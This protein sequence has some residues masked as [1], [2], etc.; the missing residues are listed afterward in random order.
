MR[1]F[2]PR[3]CTSVGLIAFAGAL[4]LMAGADEHTSYFP[5]LFVAFTLLG[6]GAGMSFMPLLT[7]ALAAVPS[8][9]AGLAS[10]M[11]NVSMQLSAAVGLAVLGSISSARTSAL[12]AQ[13]VA[14]NAAL[15]DGFHVAFVVAAACVGVGLI[16]AQVCLPSPAAVRSADEHVAAVLDA[17]SWEVDPAA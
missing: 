2:G 17:E 16:A 14:Q 8:E 4:V 1:R 6:V 10:G 7:I 12:L 15:I 13:G 11:V 9:D 3:L 5:R